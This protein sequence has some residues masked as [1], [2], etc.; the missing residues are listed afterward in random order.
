MD[1]II[2]LIATDASASDVS[3]KI[4]DTLFAKAAERV[5]ASKPIVAG[6]VF[7]NEEPTEQEEE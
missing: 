2:D 4:K 5:E 1:D 6:A 3:D 7:G